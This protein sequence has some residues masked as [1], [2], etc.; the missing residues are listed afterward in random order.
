MRESLATVSCPALGAGE[1]PPP[2]TTPGRRGV[3]V[4]W[5]PR[6]HAVPRV[7]SALAGAFPRGG[8]TQEVDTAALP[9]PSTA[10]GEA[11]YDK[12]KLERVAAAKEKKRQMTYKFTPSG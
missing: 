12:N 6:R 9:L 4:A 7:H 5:L 8:P 3:Q 10:Q 11:Y 2:V 1:S